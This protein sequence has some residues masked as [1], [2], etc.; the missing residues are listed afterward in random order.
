MN[1]KEWEW[2]EYSQKIRSGDVFLPAEKL[3]TSHRWTRDAGKWF[4]RNF[5][6]VEIG[7]GWEDHF[8]NPYVL[9]YS[10]GKVCHEGSLG[11]HTGP[12]HFPGGTYWLLVHGDGNVKYVLPKHNPIVVG[13]GFRPLIDKNIWIKREQNNESGKI[14]YRVYDS[15][16]DRN[17]GPFDHVD[18]I[19]TTILVNIK[20]KW[21]ELNA[22]S[23]VVSP[24]F[25]LEKL[26]YY[27]LFKHL[28]EDDVNN[29]IRRYNHGETI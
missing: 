25:D 2:I 21:A 1:T 17:H 22:R 23:G 10:N 20:K 18:G 13:D 28:D 3:Y 7:D 26:E 27:L 11:V 19:G 8:R 16:L 14:K 9:F 29:F 24:W 4:D 6:Y 12:F 5:F 15:T